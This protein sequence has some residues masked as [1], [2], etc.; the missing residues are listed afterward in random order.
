MDGRLRGPPPQEAATADGG[1]SRNPLP[2]T[3]YRSPCFVVVLLIENA[4]AGGLR[5][6][7]GT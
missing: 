6:P 1:A 5:A 2:N 3:T 4:A 7:S